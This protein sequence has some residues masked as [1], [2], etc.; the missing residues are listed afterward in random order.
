MSDLLVQDELELRVVGTLLLSDRQLDETLSLLSPADFTLTGARLLYQAMG[1]LFLAGKPTDQLSVLLEAGD[2]CQ[3]V[4][5]LI[6]D[7]HLWT[8]DEGLVHYREE[9]RERSR[10]RQVRELAEKLA[11]AESVETAQALT[12]QIAG[13]F[14]ARGDAKAVTLGEAAVDFMTALEARPAYLTWGIPRLDEELFVEPGDFVVIGGYASSGKTLLSL[15]MALGLA[16]AWRVGYFSLETSTRK[17]F[18]RLVSH[19]A[20]VSLKKIKRRQL[21]AA[22]YDAL[23]KAVT[24]LDKLPLELVQ[25]GGMSVT[26]I[27]AITLQKRY[28]VIFVDYLQLADAPGRDRYEK[29]TAISIGLHTLAQAHGVT[30]IALAQLSRPE[31][32]RTREGKMIP[33]SMSSFR[34]SGQIE[35]DADVAMLLYP[36][37]PDNNASNRVLK[38]S[39]NKD[40]EKLSMELAF[41]G[42]TQTLTPVSGDKAVA[43][44][45]ANDGRKA[46]EH[47]R[48]QALAGFQELDD[49]EEYQF[50]ET[51]EGVPF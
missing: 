8:S 43:Q 6:L 19:K 39:K 9:L 18:D 28:Q 14:A 24:T 51:Y 4:V 22:E 21:A 7:N 33:P 15:Q 27:Q 10:L 11:A 26:D 2:D 50:Q 35:Q 20:G 42:A 5:D 1:K 41:D 13:A 38:V 44:K 29:V 31:R 46:R 3:A 48:Q 36:T 45:L 17:L 49:D 32:T 23:T 25:A 37:D 30:V 34:E 12:G 47:N 40:G 16:E